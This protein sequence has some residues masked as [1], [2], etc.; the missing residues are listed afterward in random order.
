MKKKTICFMGA[1]KIGLQCLKLLWSY[2]EESSH[3]LVTVYTNERGSE[4]RAF[5]K[6]IGVPICD[7]LEELEEVD[8]LISVQYHRILKKTHIDK[9]RELAFNLHMAPL[10]EYRGCNQFS[11]ALLN[12]DKE[13]GTTIH[14]IDEGVDSGDI[15][16]EK[17]FQIPENCLIDELYDLTYDASI[18]L[19]REEVPK[20]V[21]GHYVSV[22]QD[23]LLKDRS[24]SLHYRREIEELKKID[25]NWSEEKILS[26]I[27]ATSMPGFPP[28]YAEIGD[29]KIEFLMNRKP[30]GN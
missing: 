21:C 5:A 10:P 13:F 24:C 28:P 25:L 1:K 22:A 14:K 8:F 18:E 23:S 29:F 26:H 6:E 11:F 7:R 20:I 9:A 19:F 12:G 2:C 27:C 3:Q 15:I 16:A 4:I 17:R 30:R